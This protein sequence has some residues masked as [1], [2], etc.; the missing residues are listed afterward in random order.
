[1]FFLA[2]RQEA[3]LK[4]L[5]EIYQRGGEIIPVQ[6]EPVELFERNRNVGPSAGEN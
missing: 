4:I 5:F 3:M 6:I 2:G 1:M